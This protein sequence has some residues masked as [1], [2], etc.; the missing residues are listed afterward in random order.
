MKQSP[1]KGCFT[2]VETRDG[3][4]VVP[5]GSVDTPATAEAS[6]RVVPGGRVDAPA[7]RE[8]SG[9]AA[10]DR[11]D[12]GMNARVCVRCTSR[13]G[14]PACRAL[15]TVQNTSC[16]AAVGVTVAVSA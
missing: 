4:N 11:C 9:A 10:G 7:D 15:C 14:G 13:H 2:C 1:V 8:I 5:G 16:D 6:G 3:D 12:A